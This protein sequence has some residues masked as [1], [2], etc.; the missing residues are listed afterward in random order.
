MNLD[1]SEI[2]LIP[3]LICTFESS[4]LQNRSL[5]EFWIWSLFLFVKQGSCNGWPVGLGKRNYLCPSSSVSA[6][7]MRCS[8][9]AQALLPE[10]SHSFHFYPFHGKWHFLWPHTG[11][12]LLG[13]IWGGT[14]KKEGGWLGFLGCETGHEAGTQRWKGAGSSW[15]HRWAEEENYSLPQR[16]KYWFQILCFK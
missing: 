8:L 12:A 16:W 1:V 9:R 11:W 7:A 13:D 3:N 15:M 10:H 2:P 6:D 5:T 4:H 14:G